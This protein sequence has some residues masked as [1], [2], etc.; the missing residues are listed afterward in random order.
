MA[1]EGDTLLRLLHNSVR[2]RKPIAVTLS[3]RKW[4]MGY[5]VTSPNLSLLEKYFDLRPIVSGYR[6]SD[7]LQVKKS[8]FY[9]NAYRE[10]LN[11]SDFAITIP[12]ASVTM[13]QSL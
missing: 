1:R 8:T 5:V 13:A 11:L 6:D 2:E 7:S 9:E 3:N 4:Y 10:D 12:L